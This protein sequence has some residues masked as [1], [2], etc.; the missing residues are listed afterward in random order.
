MG[1]LES[2]VGLGFVARTRAFSFYQTNNCCISS[3]AQKRKSLDFS[4]QFFSVIIWWNISLGHA[5]GSTA[6]GSFTDSVPCGNVS[7]VI[8]L[9]LPESQV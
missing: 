1:I 8:S 4:S 7:K 3:L 5:S 6:V 9:K 2:P